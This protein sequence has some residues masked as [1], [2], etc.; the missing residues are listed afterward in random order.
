MSEDEI[1]LKARKDIAALGVQLG[2][3]NIATWASKEELELVSAT[4][5]IAD[6]ER[7]QKEYAA[8]AAAFEEAENSKHTARY[9]QPDHLML[10]RF[11]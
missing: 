8:R 7:M 2:K 10:G 6:L 9:I 4:P 1:R 11:F 3:M 5:T